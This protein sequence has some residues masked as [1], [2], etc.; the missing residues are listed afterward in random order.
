MNIYHIEIDNTQTSVQHVPCRVPVAMKQPLK[1]KLA[2]LTKQG[3]ITKVEEQTPWISNM[4]TI[5]KP[6]KLRLCIDP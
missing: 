6:G 2:E 4:V 3:I 1:N 5:M